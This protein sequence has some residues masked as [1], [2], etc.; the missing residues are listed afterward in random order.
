M[1]LAASSD[2]S[3]AA[4]SAILELAQT[5]PHLTGLMQSGQLR[6]PD[7][8][9]DVVNMLDHAA[10]FFPTERAR[11]FDRLYRPDAQPLDL[12]ELPHADETEL[13]HRLRHRRDPRGHRRRHRTATSP[14]V[15]S[16]SSRAVSPDLMPITFGHGLERLPPTRV[17]GFRSWS[18]PVA[19]S[20]LVALRFVRVGLQPF[21]VGYAV[22]TM[23]SRVSE[24][25]TLKCT[26]TPVRLDS[27]TSTAARQWPRS[28]LLA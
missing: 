27:A 10:Y 15:R 23:N 24:L 26:V 14:A 25:V 5:V 1:G 21:G 9:T 20:G 22:S 6:T 4:G 17:E 8:A 7:R 2:P 11:W 12:T 3:R 19:P 16:A 18:G 28:L 13:A